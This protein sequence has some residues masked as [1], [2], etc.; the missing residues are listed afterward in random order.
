M[1]QP[2]FPGMRGDF[3]TPSTISLSRDVLAVKDHSNEKS[4]TDLLILDVY[5]FEVISG[6]MICD[7]PVTHSIDISELFLNKQ[8]SCAGR[9]L[10]II[11]KN[12]DLYITKTSKILL[13]KLGNMAETCRWNDETDSFSA[14]VDSKFVIWYYPSAVFVDEDIAPLTR[15]ERDGSIYGS[16]AQIVSFSGSNCTIRRADGAMIAVPNVSP[17]P[18]ILQAFAQRKQWEKA[19][20]LCR[21]VKNRELWAALAA[22]SLSNQELNTAEVAY[23]AVDE[24]N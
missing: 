24:V 13:S 4:K 10:V 20:R 23:A 19:I 1:S 7:S 2:K 8:N 9:Q 11:D 15:F 12:R 21:H 5:L 17:Y 22:M 3:I 16:N 14:I 6:R 18:G